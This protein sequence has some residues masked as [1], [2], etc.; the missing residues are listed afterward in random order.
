MVK[1]FINRYQE[2]IVKFIWLIGAIFCLYFILDQDTY[3]IDTKSIKQIVA[4]GESMESFNYTLNGRKELFSYED[5]RIYNGYSKNRLTRRA[6]CDRWDK[7]IE[8]G[9][10][11]APKKMMELKVAVVLLSC[12]I[13]M[14]L[15]YCYSG[16]LYTDRYNPSIEYGKRC[17]WQYHIT[18]DKY[19]CVFCNVKEYCPHS[20]HPNKVFALLRYYQ[21]KF[22]GY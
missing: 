14:A 13:L 10:F 11:K 5:V 16:K 21:I 6:R 1:A 19:S 3:Y 8:Q 17:Q 20:T 7:F 9:Y 18:R 22:K 4:H 12:I 15:V 2:E